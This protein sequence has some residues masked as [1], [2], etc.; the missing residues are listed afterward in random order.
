MAQDHDDANLQEAATASENPGSEKTGPFPALLRTVQELDISLQ[1]ILTIISVFVVPFLAYVLGMPLVLAL[2][3]GLSL[4][5]WFL[6][7]KSLKYTRSKTS[8]SLVGIFST[9]LLA[10]CAT[11]IWTL[12]R[13]QITPPP[14]AIP[15]TGPAVANGTCNGVN[16]GNGGRVDVNCKDQDK[17]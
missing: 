13:P 5:V 9:V 16:S 4:V 14:P 8:I 2:A 3:L 6:I 12:E 17:K 11:A 1:N 15:A 10:G 7:V